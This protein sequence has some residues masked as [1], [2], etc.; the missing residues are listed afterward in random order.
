MTE[1]GLT[2]KRTLWQ[3]ALFTLLACFL[4]SSQDTLVKWLS[5]DY[6]L[7][8]LLLVRSLLSVPVL[9]LAILVRFGRQGLTTTN[10]GAHIFR[11][12]LN[13][14]AFLSYYFAISRMPLVDAISIVSAS[15]LFLTLLSGIVLAEYP[16]GRQVLAI[17]TGFIGVIFI[18]QPSGSSVDWLG[19]GAAVF[20]CFL[21]AAL[22]IQTRRMSASESTELMLL[23]GALLV[24]AVSL[25]A[26]PFLWQTPTREDFALMILLGLVG[27]GGQYALTNGFKYAPVYLVGTLEYSTLGWAAFYGW[28]VFNDLPGASV[29]AGAA[30]VVGSGIV[31]LASEQDKG[32]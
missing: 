4:F 8:Q 20:G 17:I 19:A 13:L 12:L 5:S 27:L 11:A 1:P 7:L 18:V 2:L 15:P 10:S 24:L 25:L 26:A 3:G 21:F 31:V 23:T 22:G 32:H 9:I 29:M 28:L 16:N 6:T 30:L 14:V